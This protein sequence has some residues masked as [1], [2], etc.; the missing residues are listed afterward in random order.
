MI[1]EKIKKSERHIQHKTLSTDMDGVSEDD[2]SFDGYSYDD[3][4]STNSQAILF[5]DTEDDTDDF[6]QEADISPS[7]PSTSDCHRSPNLRHLSELEDDEESLPVNPI[8][9]SVSLLSVPETVRSISF[10]DP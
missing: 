5:S 8:F 9:E 6:D 3:S 7:S 10:G 4:E 2:L 1:L